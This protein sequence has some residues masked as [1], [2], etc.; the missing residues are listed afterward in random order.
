MFQL[1]QS[2]FHRL[3]YSKDQCGDFLSAQRLIST[4]SLE[5]T[6]DIYREEGDS[7][8]SLEEQIY[9]VPENY[10]QD[11][12]D[13]QPQPYIYNQEDI[14]DEGLTLDQD[15]MPEEDKQEAWLH[16]QNVSTF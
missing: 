15:Y 11:Q 5:D 12:A 1:F 16:L 13:F 2:L 8:D 3:P 9:L 10:E 14:D 4:D 7:P 6:D